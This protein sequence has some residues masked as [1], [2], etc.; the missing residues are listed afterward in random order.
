MCYADNT[1][2]LQQIQHSLRE[3]ISQAFR[4]CSQAVRDA[5]S[6]VNGLH[7]L[8]RFTAWFLFS[9]GCLGVVLS[10]IEAI[11]KHWKA[12]LSNAQEKLFY[13]Y[14]SGTRTKLIRLIR[15]EYLHLLLSNLWNK[16]CMYY[17]VH[18]FG[19]IL[20]DSR[21]LGALASVPYFVFGITAF[22]EFIVKIVVG[23]LL[24]IILI[25]MEIILYVVLKAV[26]LLLRPIIAAVS[27]SQLKTQHCMDCYAKI[28]KPI[29]QC[30]NCGVEHAYI[31]PGKYGLFYARCSCGKAIHILPKHQQNYAF[32]CPSCSSK[33]ISNRVRQTYVAVIACSGNLESTFIREMRI[34]YAAATVGMSKNVQHIGS[35]RILALTDPFRTSV[36][37]DPADAEELALCHRH[38][39]SV[40]SLV[41]CAIPAGCIRNEQY[42]KSPLFMEQLDGICILIDLTG[43]SNTGSQPGREMSEIVSL[44]IQQFSTMT[45]RRANRLSPVKTAVTVIMDISL[46]KGSSDSAVSAF[47]RDCLQKKGYSAAIEQLESVFTNICYFVLNRKTVGLTFDREYTPRMLSWLLAGYN[48]TAC[49]LLAKH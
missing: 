18:Q 34:Q 6:F 46:P 24:A 30:P 35:Q 13:S 43:N 40:D 9:L 25:P 26:I 28:K 23:F 37:I 29:M 49:D 2:V 11:R 10:L 36:T 1:S 45:G 5:V 8:L 12:R 38:R 17:W 15:H 39:H 44:F 14:F 27:R 31:R 20:L 4:V 42:E 47:C 19:G 21:I 33:L 16:A 32:R 41:L 22:I 3:W 7:P 48:N